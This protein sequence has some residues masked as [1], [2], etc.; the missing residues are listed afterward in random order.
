MGAELT[1]CEGDFQVYTTVDEFQHVRSEDF[2]LRVE[3][4]WLHWYQLSDI[5]HGYDPYVYMAIEIDRNHR[6]TKVLQ[7]DPAQKRIL[8]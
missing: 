1:R 6:I 2:E 8:A 3:M 4:S 5:F 7:V